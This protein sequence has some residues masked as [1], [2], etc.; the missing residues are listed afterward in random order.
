S[1]GYDTAMMEIVGADCGVLPEHISPNT[2]MLAVEND[3]ILGFAHLQQVDIP[4]TIYLEDLFIEPTAQG[5]GIGKL[6]FAWAEQ[7]A[8][9]LGHTWLEWESDPNATPFYEKVGGI[10]IKEVE[11]DNLPGR[12]I[13]IFRKRLIPNT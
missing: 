4:D 5:R 11:S 8:V 9:L 13:P 3:I 1:H 7:Q 2:T 10:K 12:M 6:L